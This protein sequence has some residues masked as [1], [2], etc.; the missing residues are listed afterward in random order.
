MQTEALTGIA[1]H[2]GMPLSLT[3]AL[4]AM[5]TFW[6]LMGVFWGIGKARRAARHRRFQRRHFPR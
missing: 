2:C 1:T 5:A 4:V 6:A 3:G